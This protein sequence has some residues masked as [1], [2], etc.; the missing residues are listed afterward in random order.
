[1]E[2]ERKR[3]RAG[4]FCGIGCMSFWGFMPIYWKALIPIDSFLIIF[5]RIVLVGATC[6]IAALFAYKAEGILKTLKQKSV[7]L[8][9]FL[10]GLLITVNWSLYIY[11]VNSGQIIE[12]CIGYYIEPLV[13]CLFGFIFFKERP[14]KYKFIAIMF[15]CAAVLLILIYFMRLPVI[16]LCLASSFGIYTALKKHLKVQAALSLFFETIFITPV[17]L[18]LIV[19]LELTGQGALAAGEQYQFVLLLFAGILTAVPLMMFTAAANRISMLSLGIIEYIAPSIS[20]FVGIFVFH[21]PF[22]IVQFA[23]FV[24]IW[25]GLVF[26][27]YGE[28]KGK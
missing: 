17:F 7:V 27:T 4:M 11:A 20:L 6:L 28:I 10:S 16:A 24:I 12:A 18:A 8:K 1:M 19:Y 13:V 23:A 3:Y 14:S 22:D 21:E 25:I 9:L 2:D 15:A 5:Y 26:F